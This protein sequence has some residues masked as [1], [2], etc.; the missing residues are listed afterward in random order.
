[1]KSASH[2]AIL[3]IIGSVIT[4]A[5]A[6]PAGNEVSCFDYSTSMETAADCMMCM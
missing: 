4:I 1:M 6:K 2:I 3:I 5:F